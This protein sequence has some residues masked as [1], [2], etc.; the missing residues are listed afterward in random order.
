MCFGCVVSEDN[1]STQSHSLL[2]CKASQFVACNMDEASSMEE[3][4]I[5]TD[6][7]SEDFSSYYYATITTYLQHGSYP[8][9]A[10]KQEKHGLQKSVVYCR[11]TLPT[12]PSLYLKKL[13]IS[14]LG[15]QATDCIHIMYTQHMLYLIY[16]H[17][18]AGLR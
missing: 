4:D 18:H 13:G 8:L 14:N 17:A 10:D 7:R 15:C 12:L 5:E 9:N 6:I 11:P 16:T 2:L 1:Q 3:V